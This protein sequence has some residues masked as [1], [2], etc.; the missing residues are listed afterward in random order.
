MTGV[1]KEHLDFI[2]IMRV[3]VQ[4]VFVLAEA[5]SVLRQVLHG[6]I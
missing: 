6:A 4:P 3:A 2:T 1:K 5:P